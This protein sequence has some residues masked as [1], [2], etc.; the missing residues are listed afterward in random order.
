MAA[1]FL[2]YD[3]DG[4]LDLV[5]LTTRGLSLW[6]NV[7]NDFV[8]VGAQSLPSSVRSL[9]ATFGGTGMVSSHAALVSGDIDRD[10]DVD[11]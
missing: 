3:N 8:Q 10:G 5:G 2:D 7:G 1:Q 6:R 4:L 9:N 11:L